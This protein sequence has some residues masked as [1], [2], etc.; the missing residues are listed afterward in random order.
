MPLSTASSFALITRNKDRH[1]LLHACSHAAYACC[2]D[3]L[4]L[5]SGVYQNLL[6]FLSGSGSVNR[7]CLDASKNPITATFS[8][9]PDT[10]CNAPAFWTISSISALLF[11]TDTV[12][13][14][15][16]CRFRHSADYTEVETMPKLFIKANS[17]KRFQISFSA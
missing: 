13:F 4:L 8:R 11:A 7:I 16:L 2:S 1:L 12:V 6:S 5:L 9:Y 10:N 17:L 3:R 15:A 14:S